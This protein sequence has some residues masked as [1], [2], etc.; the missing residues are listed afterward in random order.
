MIAISP[1]T[2]RTMLAKG[3]TATYTINTYSSSD[4][5]PRII[6]NNPNGWQR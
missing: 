1:E 4:T 2:R 3:G 5:T 6:M